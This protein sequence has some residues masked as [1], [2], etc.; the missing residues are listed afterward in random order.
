MWSTERVAGHVGALNWHAVRL[1]RLSHRLHESGHKG[2]ATLVVAANR[3]LTGV[4]IP[5]SARFGE[6]L[7]IMHG[8]G[9][10]VHHATRAG[11]ECTLYQQVTI[12][13]T[14]AHGE[15]PTLG[16]GVTV[17][18]G[19]KVL[20]PITV[21]DRATIGA[22]AVVIRDVPPQRTAVGVPARLL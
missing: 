5:A 13:S 20:G 22:N 4:D 19:A 12:G 1:Y 2:C 21:G 10:V 6:G 18:P 17:F 8:H 9:I 15:P 16:E 3:V 14:S 11:R 7:V